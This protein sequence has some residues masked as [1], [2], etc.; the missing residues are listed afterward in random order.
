MSYVEAA[1]A[2]PA[3]SLARARQAATDTGTALSAPASTGADFA[4]VFAIA[5]SSAWLDSL[6]TRQGEAVNARTK[7]QG[8]EKETTKAQN[9]TDRSRGSQ[10]TK[11][12][13][14]L[15]EV[16]QSGRSQ[17]E[18][19]GEQ[20]KTEQATEP[21]REVHTKSSERSADRRAARQPAVDGQQEI[22]SEQSTTAPQPEPVET[23][24]EAEVGTSDSVTSGSADANPA[25][26]APETTTVQAIAANVGTTST[27][28]NAASVELPFNL[29][30]PVNPTAPAGPTVSTSDAIVTPVIPTAGEPGQNDAGARQ[31]TAASAGASK[32]SETAP[33]Q[34]GTS[35]QFSTLLEHVGR[36]RMASAVRQ[37]ASANK[38]AADDGVK[39][40]RSEG[41][42][43][44]AR[45]VRSG[46]GGRHSSMTLRL[47]PP[48]LGQ[49]K[50]DVRMN[51]QNLVVRFQTETR[52][53]HDLL[54]SRM[55]EL[56]QAL[57]QHGVQLNRV[58]VEV[59]PP[60]QPGQTGRESDGQTAQHDLPHGG[61]SGFGQDR[62]QQGGARESYGLESSSSHSSEGW[63]GPE[64]S[65]LDGSRSGEIGVSAETGVDLIV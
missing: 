18:R 61:E 47:D 28:G 63:P 15:E 11:R 22:A 51:E 65:G 5:R 29:P 24:A 56:R 36:E 45:V 43:Q 6:M 1:T 46:L 57:E 50:V 58:D 17:S 26:I 42:E 32:G 54:E 41:I 7:L 8:R 62:S 35:T 23:A 59:R 21:D 3:V 25:A 60:A 53:A 33:K 10:G 39:L 44:L 40:T 49:L 14:R 64:P 27:A 55:G 19:T 34:A 38:P 37:A 52:V 30:A 48:E 20:A 12:R 2:D 13:E 9:H 31:D 4:S 16:N